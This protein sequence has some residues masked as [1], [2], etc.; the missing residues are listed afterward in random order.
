M[1]YSLLFSSLGVGVLASWL[2]ASPAS[3]QDLAPPPPMAAP[4]PADPNA[5]PPGEE[6]KLNKDE[7]KDSGRGLEWLYLDA[8]GGFSYIDMASFSASSLGLAQTSSA[9]GAFGVGAGIRLLILTLGA[10]ATINELSAFNL[11]QL[12][13]ELGFHIPIGHFEPYFGLH[14]GY[15]FVGT[16]D[17]SAIGSAASG[18]PNV[19]VHGGDAGLQV[20]LDYYFNHYISLGLEVSGN[21]LF[22]HRPPVSLPAGIPVSAIPPSEQ[23]LYNGSGDSVG[24]GVIGSL[25]VGLHL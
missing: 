23:Q 4:A 22:L 15:A 17:A 18:S 25:H 6:G 3:A 13:G 16:L 19:A 8:H 1:R 24:L 2:L 11:W 21:A 7:K 14:G 12:D 9:G 10:R 20:G 5:P